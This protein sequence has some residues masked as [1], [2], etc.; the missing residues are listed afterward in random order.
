MHEG[1]VLEMTSGGE[2]EHHT[3]GRALPPVPPRGKHE[4][5]IS[6]IATCG[7]ACQRMPP[8]VK[9]KEARS[10]GLYFGYVRKAHLIPHHYRPQKR[11]PIVDQ[12]SPSE[13]FRMIHCQVG[14][15]NI[16]TTS[17][18]ETLNIPAYRCQYRQDLITKITNKY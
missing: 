9:V 8:V 3:T 13:G 7:N 15:D 2:L 10:L 16:F 4:Y 5:S 17:G 18:T 11:T 1:V 6:M 12:N 14:E